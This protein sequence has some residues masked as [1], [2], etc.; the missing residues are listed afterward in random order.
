MENILEAGD[1]LLPLDIYRYYRQYGVAGVAGVFLSLASR[2]A[3]LSSKDEQEDWIRK[4]DICRGILEGWW[5]KADQWV[6]PPVLVTGYDL[7]SEF[8]LTPGPQI[9]IL[10]ESLR[11][12]QVAEGYSSRDQALDYISGQLS[13][14]SEQDQ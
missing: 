6:D 11:E 13:R 14:G 1:D 4:L 3:R 10:L 9:G 8:G 12:A 2:S 5:E 7:Q